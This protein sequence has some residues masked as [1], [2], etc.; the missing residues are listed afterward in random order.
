MGKD[1]EKITN[2]LHK[3]GPGFMGHIPIVYANN[4]HNSSVAVINRCLSENPPYEEGAFESIDP[5]AYINYEGFE[6]I[7]EVSFK[8]WNKPFPKPRREQHIKALKSLSER[9]IEA[10]DLTRESFVKVEKYNKSNSDGVDYSDPR[11][12]QGA[13]ARAN[14]ILG[15]PMKRYAKFLKAQWDGYAE[16]GGVSL[17]YFCDNNEAA[18]RWMDFHLS[19]TADFI[20]II[21]LGDDMLAVVRHLGI[22]YFICND[23]SRFDKTIQ[24]PALD[25]E[26]KI[27]ETSGYFD[28]DALF[29][30]KGQRKSKGVMRTGIIYQSK[31]GRNSGDP[32][33]SCGNSTLNGITSAEGI[34]KHI[35]L[36]GTK[37]FVP[38]M[39]AHYSRFGFVAKPMVSTELCQVDF[40]SKLFWPT[41]DGTVLGPKPGRCLPKMGYSCRKLSKIEI[42]STMRGWLLDGQ[43]VPGIAHLIYKYF[44][45]AFKEE[46]KVHF[47]N[48]Y[49]SHCI[50]LHEPTEETSIFFEQR[51]GISTINFMCALENA[52]ADKPSII[53]CEM[54]EHLYSKD[55]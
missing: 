13:S 54:F 23:F 4:K 25:Y 28:E 34:K 40:C 10:N 5:K 53:E 44:P 48:E 38:A 45:K 20:A 8:N 42:L 9:P 52:M 36:L 1:P 49:S 6:E 27:Y 35:H 46:E 31:D 19:R 21:I 29:V 51:Y 41:A 30:L 11:L 18:G 17:Y 33:T 43:F 16:R 47:E 7:P 32:N 37:E 3:I 24:D 39:E 12:I 22:T 14:V 26:H 55:N 2:I 15:P 50:S